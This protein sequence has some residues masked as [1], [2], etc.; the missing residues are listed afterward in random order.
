MKDGA[1]LMLNKQQTHLSK[2][3]SD[4]EQEDIIDDARIAV[5]KWQKLPHLPCPKHSY[6]ERKRRDHFLS[7]WFVYVRFEFL[8]LA[9]VITFCFFKL[10]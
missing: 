9:T 8:T 1:V 7:T 4:T 10:I 3:A 5:S 2:S 6:A